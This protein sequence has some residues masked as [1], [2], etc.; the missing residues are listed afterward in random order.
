[1]IL[2]GAYLAKAAIKK[3]CSCGI[4]TVVQMSLLL[5]Y[6]SNRAFEVPLLA[7]WTE[8]KVLAPSLNGWLGV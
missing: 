7:I 2:R 5:Y 4:C 8:V 3:N 6:C 1:M